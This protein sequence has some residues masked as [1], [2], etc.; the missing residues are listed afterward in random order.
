MGR[1]LENPAVLIVLLLVLVI[2]FGANKLP[3][4]AKSLGQSLR[5]FKNEMRS[6]EPKDV[7]AAATAS[8]SAD[9]TSEET[10]RRLQPDQ[11]QSGNDRT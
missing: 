7:P 6:D 10:M 11:P 3:V 1:F 5:I 8:T 4:A 2:V 9:E